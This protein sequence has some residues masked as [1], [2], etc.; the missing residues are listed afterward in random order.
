MKE[1]EYS[2]RQKKVKSSKFCGLFFGL[3]PWVC[4]GEG[5]G[6]GGGFVNSFHAKKFYQIKIY[7]EY[8]QQTNEQTNKESKKECNKT[9]QMIKKK[10]YRKKLNK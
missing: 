7:M 8:V 2:K 6:E 9:K 5:E 4:A 1:G 3:L 10:K